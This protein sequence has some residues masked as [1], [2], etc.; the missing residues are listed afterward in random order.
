VSSSPQIESSRRA[1]AIADWA[2]LPVRERVLD[3]LGDLLLDAEAIL[4]TLNG[5][6]AAGVRWIAPQ[7]R[8]VYEQVSALLTRMAD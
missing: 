6:D 1:A 5:D 3:Q 8:T 7:V 4:D 2:C